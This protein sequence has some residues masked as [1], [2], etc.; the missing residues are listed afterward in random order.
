MCSRVILFF[1]EQNGVLRNFLAVCQKKGARRVRNGLMPSLVVSS[2]QLK[3]CKLIA[4]TKSQIQ[5][6]CSVRGAAVIGLRYIKK[7]K[8]LKLH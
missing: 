6:W 4:Q 5:M 2:S 7:Q 8:H 1:L 3:M